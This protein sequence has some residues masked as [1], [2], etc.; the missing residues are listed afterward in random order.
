MTEVK[1]TTRT[2]KTTWFAK[3]ARK[4]LIKDDELCDAIREVMKGQVDDLGGG[5]FKSA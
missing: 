3:V 2:F 4:A 5:V 1:E